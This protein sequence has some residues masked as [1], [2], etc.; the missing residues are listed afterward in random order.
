MFIGV[1]M[2]LIDIYKIPVC[3]S[4]GGGRDDHRGV[5]RAVAAARGARPRP[6]PAART[7]PSATADGPAA[8]RESGMGK[9]S[10]FALCHFAAVPLLPLPH[11]A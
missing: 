5:D 10:R 11:A 6:L 2:L 3:V 1:K 4:L 7:L 8:M 9:K